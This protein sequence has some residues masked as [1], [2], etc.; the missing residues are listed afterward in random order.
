MITGLLSDEEYRQAVAF[1]Y[2][3]LLLVDE[4]RQ[5]DIVYSYVGGLRRPEGSGSVVNIVAQY[6]I[7]LIG[8]RYPRFSR[9]RNFP[10]RKCWHHL[11]WSAPA[12]RLKFSSSASVLPSS[13]LMITIRSSMNSAV[14]GRY[15]FLVIIGIEVVYFNEFVDKIFSVACW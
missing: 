5:A 8:F 11:C 13:R 3:S 4:G 7:R 10:V 14:F 9:I 12:L 15:Q 1:Q 2:H 6:S